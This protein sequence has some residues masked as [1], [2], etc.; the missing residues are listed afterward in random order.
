MDWPVRA[1]HVAKLSG[2]TIDRNI[3]FRPAAQSAGATR[4]EKFLAALRARGH[5]TASHY[6]DPLLVDY[7]NG[8]FRFRPDSPAIK[9]GI[10]PLDLSTV[11]LTKDFPKRLRSR[12]TAEP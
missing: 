2:C 3:Y 1:E 5:D 7:K 8:D 10:V 4:S 11:G 6:G 9:L 12:R